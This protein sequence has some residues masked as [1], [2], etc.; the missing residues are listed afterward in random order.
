MREGRMRREW[1]KEEGFPVEAWRP[2]D[3]T[4]NTEQKWAYIL[5][6]VEGAAIIGYPT[7]TR[8]PAFSEF[9][10]ICFARGLAG[11]SRPL[12]NGCYQIITFV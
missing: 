11:Q 9:R 8:H 5:T 1:L 4:G 10:N 3:S 6:S 7:N 2:L 12:G